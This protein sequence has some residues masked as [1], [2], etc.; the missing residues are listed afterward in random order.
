MKEYKKTTEMN[1]QDQGQADMRIEH[2]TREHI[3]N[4]MTKRTKKT[5]TLKTDRAEKEEE[6]TVV[7]KGLEPL[8]TEDERHENTARGF[9]AWGNLL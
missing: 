2:P 3:E 6:E 8:A 5:T 9:H 7:L 4:T 1:P